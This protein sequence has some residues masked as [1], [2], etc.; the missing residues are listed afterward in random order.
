VEESVT[1]PRIKKDVE[2]GIG[3]LKMVNDEG[4][5]IFNN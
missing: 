3:K 1:I 2:T 5:L 4:R